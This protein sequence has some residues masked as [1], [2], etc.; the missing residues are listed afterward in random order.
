[1]KT[2]MSLLVAV[3]AVMI[4]SGASASQVQSVGDVR[5]RVVNYSDL[6][7]SNQAGAAVLYQ[8]INHAAHIVCQ[9][10]I[11]WD[12]VVAARVRNCIHTAR[13]RSV[14]EVNAP[15]LTRYFESR[16]STPTAVAMSTREP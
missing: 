2:K 3:T 11:P 7:L 6:N 1:M 15:E 16:Q 10:P 4:V 8:R 9:L 5:Q 12:A 13:A 14:S